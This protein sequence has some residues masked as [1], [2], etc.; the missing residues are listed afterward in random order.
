MQAGWYINISLKEKMSL[1]SLIDIEPEPKTPVHEHVH[2]TM[3]LKQRV[4]FQP[5]DV[6]L[7]RDHEDNILRSPFVNTFKKTSWYLRDVVKYTKDIDWELYSKCTLFMVQLGPQA[8]L[9]PNGDESNGP[10]G[11]EIKLN[12]NTLQRCNDYN[13][14]GEVNTFFADEGF[15]L[16][17]LGPKDE[18]EL[19]S[20]RDIYLHIAYHDDVYI[21]YFHQMTNTKKWISYEQ[22][23]ID[24]PEDFMLEKPGIVF[25][26]A[27]ID[28]TKPII[29]YYDGMKLWELPHFVVSDDQSYDQSDDQTDYCT[30]NMSVDRGV[31][32]IDRLHA[33]G[34]PEKRQIKFENV[35]DLSVFTSKMI[36]LRGYGD[37]DNKI[38][39]EMY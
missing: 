14:K 22:V 24:N 29:V 33:P 19:L 13:S 28:K 35:R 31:S 15:P 7:G 18:L 9:G 27:T 17:M 2:D 6:S 32:N 20:S 37:K 36:E 16:F 3:S 30:W 25:K 11:L 5:R 8:P 38:K 39:L 12:G 34:L 23:D 21:N 1:S 26:W 4:L 10:N